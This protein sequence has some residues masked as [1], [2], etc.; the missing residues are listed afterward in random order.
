IEG[1]ARL[2][3]RLRNA[4]ATGTRPERIRSIADTY[5]DFTIAE[6]HLVELMFAHKLDSDRESIAHSAVQA[7]SPLLEVFPSAEPTGAQEA[8][9][10]GT[11]FLATLQGLASLITCGVVQPE[12]IEGLVT[13]VVSRYA[14][15]SAQ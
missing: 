8:Q 5:L 7:F 14:P 15:P 13:D 6:P 2:G 12:Q 4:A 11:T 3:A 10:T 1:F 9:Q